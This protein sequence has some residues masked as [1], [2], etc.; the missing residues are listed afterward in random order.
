MW[1]LKINTQRIFARI[2]LLVILFS[3]LSLLLT[4]KITDNEV[5]TS[6]LPV[7]TSNLNI[8]SL[9][10][11]S[12]LSSTL[13]KN[14]Q[15]MQEV[16]IKIPPH[17]NLQNFIARLNGK[18]IEYFET[19]SVVYA[20]VPSSAVLLLKHTFGTE[21]VAEN[22]PFKAV[23]KFMTLLRQ[24]TD[25]FNLYQL[26][27]YLSPP[28]LTNAKKLWDLGITGSG[29]KIA[30]IDTG[31]SPNHPDLKDN[32]KYA[33][34]F[35]KKKYGYDFEENSDDLHG[36][37]THVAGIAAGKGIANSKFK[38]M[39]PNASIYNLKAASQ[40]G[41]ATPAGVLAA[42][43][44]AINLRVDIISMSLGYQASE[45]SKIIDDAINTAVDQGIV[46]SISA[47]NSGDNL[48][49]ATSPAVAYKA[50]AVGATDSLKRVAAF[51]SRGPTIDRRVKPDIVAPGVNIIS[52]L[53]PQSLTDYAYNSFVE[54][55]IVTGNGGNYIAFSGTSMA[56]PVVSGG[57]ALLKSAFPTLKPTQ[58]MSAL[59]ITANKSMIEN[60]Y[61]YFSYGNGF[62]DIKA[63]Y[64]Y[65]STTQDT[66]YVNP[67]KVVFPEIL[68]YVGDNTTVQIVILSSKTTALQFGIH[69]NISAL[70]KLS[71]QSATIENGFANVT[72]QIKVPLN[73][74]FDTYTGDLEINSSITNLKIPFSDITIRP[75]KLRL[76]WD[77]Y[78]N[79][80]SDS[81]LVNYYTM[82]QLLTEQGIDLDFYDQPFD[83]A[84]LSQYQG[85]I[86][87]DPEQPYTKTEIKALQDYVSRGGKLLVL[88]S[89][90]PY[91]DFQS[92]NE[93]LKPYGIQYS[94]LNFIPPVDLGFKLEFSTVTKTAYFDKNSLFYQQLNTTEIDWPLGNA[95]NI[96]MDLGEKQEVIARIKDSEDIVLAGFKNTT[97]SG[98]VLV[99]SS[100]LLF[101][102]SFLTFNITNL[103][104]EST[105]PFI[106]QALLNATVKWL[107]SDI[108]TQQRVTL[109]YTEKNT[110]MVAHPAIVTPQTNAE[111]ALTYYSLKNSNN[112]LIPTEEN[113]VTINLQ[114]PNG[115][116]IQFNSGQTFTL[117]NNRTYLSLV[118]D[119]FNQ[120]GIYK[121]YLM[122]ENT[123]I[124]EQSF[125]YD[126][127]PE[128]TNITVTVDNTN[129]NFASWTD[130][131]NEHV[132][133]ITKP[134]G[135]ATIRIYTKNRPNATYNITMESSL[136]EYPEAL[137][138]SVIPSDTNISADLSLQPQK[139][140]ENE[141]MT[142][143]EFN[144]TAPV[145][146][147]SG[148]YL[149]SVTANFGSNPN[150]PLF[151]QGDGTFI[152][153][154]DLEPTTNKTA[155]TVNGITLQKFDE[156]TTVNQIPSIDLG[157]TVKFSLTAADDLDDPSQ[158]QA[159]VLLT[160][161]YLFLEFQYIID[162][163]KMNY[164]DSTKTFSLDYKFPRER[165]LLLPEFNA[166]L[167][168]EGQIFVFIIIVRDSD[169]NYDFNVAIFRV[170]APLI[171]INTPL[172]IVFLL[173]ILVIGIAGL[174]YYMTRG[175][176]K[177]E[178]EYLYQRFGASRTQ[179]DFTYQPATPTQTSPP[180]R[181]CPQCGTPVLPTDKFCKNCG[182]QLR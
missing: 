119:D 14:P 157:D 179:Q 172:T 42:I 142:T 83:L 139:V 40:F 155:S 87:A 36:H 165:Q 128:I 151:S 61:D 51:S 22:I 57:L 124:F 167:K 136:A 163:A 81:L 101:Y 100:E 76:L 86:I 156:I 130:N 178:Q 85:V 3:G 166:N 23:P 133:I 121:L 77:A 108:L 132:P 60:D 44:K 30:I 41:S 2:M 47:G 162:S 129:Q 104:D 141:S 90:A 59:Y 95:L 34:S 160:H 79:D 52:A 97:S 25:D 75:S 74:A 106:Y 69:G 71:T 145:S 66:F 150:Q 114:L 58:L 138:T 29:S 5:K 147:G 125:L 112:Q 177:K 146:Y 135:T 170:E 11:S 35:V 6:E 32:I 48:F 140:A 67:N 8:E 37:G 64:D 168:M 27:A 53:S 92:L 65:L 73:S 103:F 137:D 120:T 21:T 54:Q 93:L 63:A 173:A 99:S 46:A 49:T 55:F 152:V 102:N 28:D 116:T 56:A 111:I 109:A 164:N 45:A 180:I 153:V 107:F 127:A 126:F 117:S 89:F 70:V 10:N 88:G 122:E 19:I 82:Y 39:A 12:Q 94:N 33:E 24:S 50:I 16:L 161:Y 9:L 31:V 26:D 182:R 176:I 159:I 17:I 84:I 78:H 13:K 134:D 171:S 148:L 98:K 72:I 80:F 174:Y 131:L 105:T 154:S 149:I 96:T 158:M 4:F 15:G 91:S 181:F 143:W 7:I 115:T 169:G 144:W 20:K 18:I 175:R 43:E 38:G 68:R 123:I 113:T 62:L 110:T 118:L 1:R